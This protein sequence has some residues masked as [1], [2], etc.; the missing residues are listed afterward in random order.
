MLSAKQES[1]DLTIYPDSDD[2]GEGELQRLICELLRPLL[3]RFLADRLSGDFHVGANQFLYYQPRNSAARIAPDV[4]VLSGVP[5]SRVEPI[6]KLWEVGPPLFCLEVVSSH[7]GKDYASSPA[8]NEKA[9]TR[10]LVVFDP[11]ADPEAEGGDR[12]LWQ[13][14]R[15]S[16]R[17]GPLKLA[18]Q[19]NH[20]CVRSVALGCYLLC[21]GEGGQRRIRLAKGFRVHELIPTDAERAEHEASRAAHEAERADRAEERVRELEKLYLG[22]PRP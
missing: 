19:S 4:Y 13:I 5:Q 9:G 8:L 3:A 14:W 1:V 20:A 21:E 17:G 7:V 10:E 15:R 6:W 11:E 18:L 22:R 2:M 16:R 12:F